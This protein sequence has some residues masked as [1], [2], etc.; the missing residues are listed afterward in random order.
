MLLF[1]FLIYFLIYGGIAAAAKP[2]TCKTLGHAELYSCPAKTCGKSGIAA[3]NVKIDCM[4]DKGE[5]GQ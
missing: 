3:P 4:W 1:A 5:S 2:A